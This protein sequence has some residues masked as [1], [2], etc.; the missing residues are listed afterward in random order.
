MDLSERKRKI[1]EAIIEDYIVSAEPIG[2][3]TI[4]KNTNM[5]LSS[6]TI[7]NEMSDLEEMGYIISPHTS[8][9]RIP[10][11]AGYR[12]YVNELMRQYKMAN[13]DII[14]LKRFF[15]A[16][17]LQLDKLIRQASSIVSQLT[18][19]T[20]VAVTPELR[21]SYIKHIELVSV[22]EHSALLVLVTNEGI[23]KNQLINVSEDAD[24]LRSFSAVLNEKITGLTLEEINL[25]VISEIQQI[26]GQS[27]P[28]LMTVLDFI[29]RTVSELD[30]SEVYVENAQNIL[31]HPEY[32]NLS[33]AKEI[34]SFLENKQ[35]IKNVIDQMNSDEN[36]SIVIGSENSVDE[37]RD[38]S[39]VTAK[40]YS[41][42]KMLGKIGIVGPTRMNYSKVIAS[43]D[44]INKNIDNI[45]NELYNE[46]KGS[47]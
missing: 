30:G 45:I 46:E 10:T 15:T 18:S 28:L 33:K 27:S 8:A 17:V 7:R 40:Y 44:Y 37:M 20:T 42:G 29:H 39:I 4:S 38:T 22:D 36:I 2:S 24:F 11:D 34:L 41:G 19:Y 23:I 21:K 43:L 31:N 9:G 47:E 26:I 6:A 14:K 35:S 13:E 32:Y 16:G 3:R 12:F 1:L 5:G 25:T